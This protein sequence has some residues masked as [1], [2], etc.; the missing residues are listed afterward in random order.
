MEAWA[1]TN[2][3][4][5][6][7]RMPF[8]AWDKFYVSLSPDNKVLISWVDGT[9]KRAYSTNPISNPTDWHYWALTFDGNRARLYIDGAS[10]VEAE[11]NLPRPFPS[12]IRLGSLND[13]RYFWNGLIESFRITN[14][15]RTPSEILE[16]YQKD[17][18]FEQD[19]GTVFLLPANILSRR[20]VFVSANDLP[21]NQLIQKGKET[22]E[23][24]AE[25]MTLSC[26]FIP[27]GP[28]EI[29]TDF[30]LGDFIQ[31]SYPNAAEAIVR[32]AGIVEE[33]SREGKRMSLVLGKESQDIK[34]LLRYYKKLFYA[35]SR[36]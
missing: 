21:D 5:G 23:E 28:F 6:S 24:M 15:V 8:S 33:W 30:N 3:E 13:N 22:L 29:G 4:S 18:L 2:W 20:E 35:T 19:R 10:V 11:T 32:V 25:K 27:H 31:V 1:K 7:H 14:R 26:E 9:Q 36:R 17:S 12:N 16:I 34:M